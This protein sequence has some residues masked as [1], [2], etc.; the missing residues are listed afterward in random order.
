MLN[1]YYNL[2][3]HIL[4]KDCNI[5]RETRDANEFK[6]LYLDYKEKILSNRINCIFLAVNRGKLSEGIDLKDEL[7]R[8]V[9]LYGVPYPH[10]YDPYIIC[11]RK[12]A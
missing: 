4:S 6:N 11:K 12:H 3:G 10:L 7:C 5:Y 8:V 2:V 1:S 9:I